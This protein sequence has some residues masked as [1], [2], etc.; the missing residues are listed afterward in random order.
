M[1][2]SLSLSLSSWFQLENLSFTRRRER[3]RS[4]F[5][6]SLCLGKNL[7]SDEKLIVLLARVCFFDSL[8]CD[9]FSIYPSDLFELSFFF[10]RLDFARSQFGF[11][12]S[13]A[14]FLCF[15]FVS[16]WFTYYAILS[17]NCSVYEI[18]SLNLFLFLI[19]L[20]MDLPNCMF[21]GNVNA[22]C[23]T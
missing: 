12:Q 11:S 13:I 5:P 15:R 17:V 2:L 3:D 21:W 10:P 19:D 8:L 20:L 7:I 4:P 16:I 9:V 1:N 14:L 6:H 23:I 18:Q 22:E